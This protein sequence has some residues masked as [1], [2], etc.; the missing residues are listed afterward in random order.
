MCRFDNMKRSGEIF[1]SQNCAPSLL[2]GI[3]QVRELLRERYPGQSPLAYTHSYGCQQ[4]VSDGE[5]LDGLLSEMGYGFCDSPEKADLVLFNTCAVRENAE[6]RVFGNVGALKAAKQRNRNMLIC[7]CGCMTQ[8][9]HIAQKFQKSYP[10]VDLVFGTHALQKFPE[11]LYRALLEKKPVID[12]TEY[13][14]GVLE[15]IPARRES[16]LKAW[17]PIMYGCNNFCTYCIV[18]HVRGREVSRKSR[19]ILREFTEL[20]QSGCREITLLGQN[21]N[22]YGKGLEEDINFS[23]LLRMLNRVEGDFRIRFMT[24]HPKDATFELIDTIAE[25]E[26]VC[27]HFHLP[28]QSGSDRILSL[29]NRRYTVAD[30]LRLVDYARERIPDIAFT[31]DIIVGFPSET[32]EDFEETLSLLKRVRY[33]SLFS[34]IYSK[35]VGTKAAEMDDPTPQKEKTARMARLLELQKEIGLANYQSLV[36]KTVAV[37]ADGEGKEKGLLS[38]RTS[39]F[40]IVEFPGKPEEIGQFIEVRITRAM[41][42]ALAGERK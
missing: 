10:Y 15:G 20:V 39:Q 1:L 38:G 19:D 25:C 35:R 11:L 37:L 32:E 12:I 23:G 22:S 30:Y 18:P 16:G 40:E 36:G 28:V 7:V 29:M 3:R 4:N 27:R 5:K 9:E 17:L 33:D 14:T 13:D 21:V 31:S 2:L 42:W 41:N 34:F 24:S 8:Q 6:D 26:K